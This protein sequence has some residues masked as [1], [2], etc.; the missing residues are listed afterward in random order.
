MPWQVNQMAKKAKNSGLISAEITAEQLERLAR[1]IRQAGHAKGLHPV[2]WE[3]LRY[4][5]RANQFSNSPGA[6]AKY[7]GA[8]KGTVSQTI[9]SLV[10]K[11]LVVKG[12]RSADSRSVALQLTEQGE[13]LLSDDPLQGVQNA[14]SALTN[15]TR[16]RFSKGV[17]EVLEAEYVRQNEPSFGSCKSCR[18]YRDG[19]ASDSDTCIK[20]T[21]DLKSSDLKL[22]CVEHVAAG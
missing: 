19:G 3:A 12:A 13:K 18:F 7:M 2:Q 4:L 6:L 9:Q 14:I 11:G 22:I 16:K 10:K 1:L 17:L 20:F 5:M 21:V 8:T 15:K